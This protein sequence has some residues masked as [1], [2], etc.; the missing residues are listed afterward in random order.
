MLSI[1][2]LFQME[3]MVDRR[4][5]KDNIKMDWNELM[6]TMKILMGNMD[7]MMTNEPQIPGVNIEEM[8][9]EFL[10]MSENYTSDTLQ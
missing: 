7:K 9:T 8:Q 10:K 4:I 1:I 5:V 2:G 3:A 6:S